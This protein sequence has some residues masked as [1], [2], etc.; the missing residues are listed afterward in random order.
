M[1]KMQVFSY[2]IKKN[3]VFIMQSMKIQRRQMF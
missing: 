2:M 3:R 1:M